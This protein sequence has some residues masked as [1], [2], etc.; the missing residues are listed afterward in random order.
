MIDV[1]MNDEEGKTRKQGWNKARGVEFS[2]SRELS[3]DAY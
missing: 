1:V 2:L 3:W